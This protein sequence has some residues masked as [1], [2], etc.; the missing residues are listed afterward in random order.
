MGKE[1]DQAKSLTIVGIVAISACLLFM[2]IRLT[3]AS[4]SDLDALTANGVYP[5]SIH[6]RA[7]GWE[8]LWGDP[9]R[10]IGEVMSEHGYAGWSG[11]PS[12]RPPSALL[13][14]TASS[15]SAG[16]RSG[17]A[18]WTSCGS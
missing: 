10:P 4:A 16:C 3:V 8:A 5:D 15:G 17:S 11:S 7:L 6:E 13:L 9:Y 12:P 2:A 18:A 14:Q 1:R